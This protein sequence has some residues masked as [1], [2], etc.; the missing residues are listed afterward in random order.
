MCSAGAPVLYFAYVIS[1]IAESC[2]TTVLL[3]QVP[4]SQVGTFMY[5]DLSFINIWV[6]S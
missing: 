2:E 5:S 1:I 4:E 6:P 3:V